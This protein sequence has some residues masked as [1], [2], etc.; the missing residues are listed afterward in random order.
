MRASR[1]ILL[2]LLL[3]L[4][5][6][7][8]ALV[9]AFLILS[10]DVPPPDDSD[11]LVQR[12]DLPDEENAFT[13]YRRALEVLV[14]PGYD[15]ADLEPDTEEA[16][17]PWDEE[18]DEEEAAREELAEA[19][20]AGEKWDEALAREL[21]K[22]NA[23]TFRHV[24]A[25]L[26]CRE[27]Q[28]PSVRTI[29]D[30][31]PY[32]LPVIFLCNVLLVRSRHLERHDRSDEALTEALKVVRIG[33]QF[34]GAKGSI[35][36]YLVGST[37]Q[38][39]GLD[40]MCE[41]L[42]RPGMETNELVSLADKLPA[43]ADDGEYLADAF[44]VEYAISCHTI[45]AVATGDFD[46]DGLQDVGPPGQFGRGTRVPKHLLK[47]NQ[48]KELIA[49]H[50]R[51]FVQNAAKPF[52]ACPADLDTEEIADRGPLKLL[53]SGNSIGKILIGMLLPPC[54]GPVVK[55]CRANVHLDAVRVL[56]AMKAF[57]MENGRLPE[58]LGEMVPE[59][60]DAVPRDD[61]DGKPLRYDRGKRILYSVGKDLTDDGGFT[62]EEARQWWQRSHPEEAKEQP[63]PDPWNLPDPSWP[64]SF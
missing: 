30:Q 3:V 44:R 18:A 7:L 16:P 43:Y 10:R 34:Q 64:I 53:L 37:L 61:F 8:V 59:H 35:I 33:Y 46:L 25:A 19:M 15:P 32:A 63:D 42:L 49:R 6:P 24:E 12:L 41:L 47:P 56:L 20:L 48:T 4:G 60:L 21:L 5:V 26:S 38:E 40:R 31:T 52:S 29:V 36:I 54:R 62:D 58:T 39:R 22:K 57:R 1:K 14:W 50:V 23:D 17:P 28:V 2:I 27:C 9:V 51:P 45:E 11:L 13:H 55:K